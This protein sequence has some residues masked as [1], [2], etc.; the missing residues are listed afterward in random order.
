[1]W[2]EDTDGSGKSIGFRVKKKISLSKLQVGMYMEVD[3]KD[4]TGGNKKVLLLGKGILLTSENQI[5][6]LQEAGLKEVVIDTSKGKDVAGGKQVDAPAPVIKMPQAQKP[7]PG[8]KEFFKEEIK[9][10]RKIRGAS[11]QVVKEFM[12][13]AATGQSI[14]TKKVQI[15]SKTLTGS[16]FRNVDALLSLTT[17]KNYSEHTYTHSVNVSILTLAIAHSSGVSEEEAE[18]IGVGGLLH[19]IGKSKIPL[20]ILDKPGPL[21]PDERKIIMSHP[22]LS[23]EILKDMGNVPEEAIAISGQHH[24]KVNGSGYPR[25][26]TGD[27]MHPFGSMAAVADIYDALTSPR[28]YKPGLPPYIALRHVFDGRGREFDEKVVDFFIKNL[29][30]YPMGSFV[31]L[32]TGEMGVV[33]ETNPQDSLKPKIGVIFTRFG[34]RRSS[35]FVADLYETTGGEERT[36]VEADDPKKY[37]VDIADYISG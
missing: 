17:L 36:I 33:I 26:L 30:I 15:A 8:R 9:V 6:R 21:T 7:P 34:K 25:G 28:P 11:I 20:E 5:R 37:D 14:D 12:G 18:V 23:E 10:A 1:M 22:L 13:N 29:G 19:D 4:S 32:N 3:V 24:E 2:W 27:Q 31:K 16:V 35:M